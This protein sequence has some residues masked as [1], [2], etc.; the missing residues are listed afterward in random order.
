M[1]DTTV[2]W[3]R[4]PQ[5]PSTKFS[6]QAFFSE[7]N[8]DSAQAGDIIWLEDYRSRLDSTEE[9]TV[10]IIAWFDFNNPVIR[11]LPGGAEKILVR[12]DDQSDEPLISV[13]GLNDYLESF[14]YR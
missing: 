12:L 5:G 8:W 6:N 2:F 4:N 1:T 14:Q 3:T 10:G 7:F 11:L 9:A 13:V